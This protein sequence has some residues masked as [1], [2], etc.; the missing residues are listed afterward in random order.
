[1]MDLI[2]TLAEIELALD[3]AYLGPD[4]LIAT[5]DAVFD[6]TPALWDQPLIAEIVVLDRHEP[7]AG[8]RAERL[9]REHNATTRL[10]AG[11]RSNEETA[12]ILLKARLEQ[13]LAGQCEPWDVC[14][15]VNPI[16]QRFDY[17]AWLGGLFHDCDWCEPGAVRKNWPHLAEAARKVISTL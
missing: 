6:A 14:Q 4:D 2:N 15:M 5:I 3:I 8:A 17:P 7:N 12:Q 1:M 13:Y 11:E 9:L 16:E 10:P